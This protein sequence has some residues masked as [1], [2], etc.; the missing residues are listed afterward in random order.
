MRH[1]KRSLA[2]LALALWA[3]VAPSLTFWGANVM[4]QNGYPTLLSG[5]TCATC[6][7]TGNISS[8][9]TFT[10]YN[11]TALVNLGVC[12]AIAQ[13]ATTG[14]S[15]N[16]GA[17]NF[18]AATLPAGYYYT[19]G[20]TKITTAGTTSSTLPGLTIGWTDTVA[21]V[22]SSVTAIGSPLHPTGNT[23]AIGSTFSA[24]PFNISAATN[25]TYATE[26]YASVGA[27][28]MQYE[29]RATLFQC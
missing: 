20:Y 3:V 28:A 21:A 13:V 16:I 19:A 4:A 27:T 17:T 25:I 15:A 10:T 23:T 12:S 11:N 6:Y 5:I 1:L 8:T 18:T 22:A 24:G 26:S 2:T 9:G 29:I 14:Q 7:F